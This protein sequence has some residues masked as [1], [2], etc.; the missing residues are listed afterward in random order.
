[1]LLTL[2]LII[3]KTKENIMTTPPNSPRSTEEAQVKPFTTS[4]PL[5]LKI[6]ATKNLYKSIHIGKIFLGTLDK[7]F[8]QRTLT[9][10]NL[11]YNFW[12]L[13]SHK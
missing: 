8:F 1:M 4:A 13:M 5:G 12:N 9:Y 6:A 2:K 11:A 7:Q 10:K 3:N